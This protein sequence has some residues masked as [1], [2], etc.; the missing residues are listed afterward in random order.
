MTHTDICVLITM[1]VVKRNYLL[2]CVKS[3]LV[4]LMQVIVECAKKE[5]SKF[6]Q[7]LMHLFR[8]LTFL[9]HPACIYSAAFAMRAAS[10]V[11]VKNSGAPLRRH[12]Y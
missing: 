3:L 7:Y 8:L 12:Y 1:K 6:G 4:S 10:R 2:T 5:I 9:D 11:Y